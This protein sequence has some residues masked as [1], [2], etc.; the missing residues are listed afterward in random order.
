MWHPPCWGQ[1]AVAVRRGKFRQDEWQCALYSTETALFVFSFSPLWS[2]VSKG[3]TSKTFLRGADLIFIYALTSIT[4]EVKNYCRDC[5]GAESPDTC[6][7]SRM[8]GKKCLGNGAVGAALADKSSYSLH[9]PFSLSGLFSIPLWSEPHPFS[10]NKWF[11]GICC[12]WASFS[13]KKSIRRN[14]PWLL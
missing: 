13:S 3:K 7:V 6:Q 1:A 5:R 14:P 12:F 8:P 9:L 11:S 10:I 4:H 2:K